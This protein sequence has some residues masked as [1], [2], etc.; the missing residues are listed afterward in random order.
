MKCTLLCTTCFSG[1]AYQ[2]L[3]QGISL[4]L[5]QAMP[6]DYIRLIVTVANQCDDFIPIDASTPI[7]SG[8]NEQSA[9]T[10]LPMET[11]IMILHNITMCR[12]QK[13]GIINVM[14]G[15]MDVQSG[16]MP[17]VD[18]QTWPSGAVDV[19]FTCGFSPMATGNLHHD[20]CSDSLVRFNCMIFPLPPL[21]R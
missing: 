13:C 7:A 18:V 4:Q 10:S 8:T 20:E 21:Y 19:Q 6:G 1:G 12:S 11:G 16:D 3:T 15:D 17:G 9:D 14:T 2:Q 5:S